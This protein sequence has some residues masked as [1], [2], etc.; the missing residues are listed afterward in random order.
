MRLCLTTFLTVTFTALLFGQ[1]VPNFWQEVTHEQVWLPETAETVT[2]PDSYRLLSL[3]MPAMREY[4]QAAPQEGSAQAKAGKFRLALP[5]PDGSMETFSAWESPIMHPELAAKFPMIKTYAGKS[6]ENPHVIIRFGYGDGGFH[7]FIPDQNGGTV[8]SR[9]AFKQSQYHLCYFNNDVPWSEID[10]PPV[11]CGHQ[12][13]EA[14]S[15]DNVP[16]V[17]DAPLTFRGGGEGKLTER[18]NYAFALACTGEYGISHGGTVPL[19]M[20]TLVQATGILNALLERDNN[21]RLVL[22]S[23]ND[24]LVFINP[25]NDPF[26]N[27]NN[28]HALLDENE[29]ALENLI[30]N[31]NYDVGH[32]FTNG[33]VDVGGVVNGQVCTGGKGRGVTC[34]GSLDVVGI[35]TR[36]AAH[37]M[38]HQFEADHTFNNCPGAGGQFNSS[39]AWEP[40]SGS[41][42][43]SYK[44]SC[45]SNNIPGAMNVHYH[46]G[47]IEEFW[48]FTHFQAGN[49]CPFKIT[50]TNHSPQVELPYTDGFFIPISTPF[51]LEAIA[52]DEDG[53]PLTYSWEQINL[54]PNSPLGMPI[55]DA[56]SFRVYDPTTTP[57]RVFPRLPTILNNGSDNTEVLPT[58]NRNLKFR[59]MVRDN[60]V[61]E[62]AGGIT[63]RDV[64]FNATTT[65]GPFLVTYPN[66][67]SVVWKGGTEVEVKWDVA[68]TTND[69]V[70]CQAVNIRLSVDGGNTYPYLLA[71]ATA[72]D[73]AE[74]VTV[75]DVS[76]SAA[77]VRVEAV[78]NIFFDLSNQNFQVQPA[79][80]PTF[81][82]TPSPLWQQVCVPDNAVLEVKTSAI[83][84]FS[85]PITFEVVDGLPAGAN[86]IFS[87]NPVPV[88]ENTTLTFDLSSVTA[89][90]LFNLTIRGVAG[91]DTI[92]KSLV[93]NVV[94]S[95]FSALKLESP[96]D[97]ATGQG[98]LPVFT[99]T[100]LPQADLYEF[101]LATSPLFEP[102]SIVKELTGLTETT[103]TPNVALLNSKIYYWRI[104]PMNE[105][106]KSNYT[107]TATFQTYTL[108]CAPFQSNDVPIAISSIGLPVIQSSLPVLQSAVITD[109][110][111]KNISG[112]HDALA[113][114]RVTLI[115]PSGTEVVLFEK[116]CGNT[117]LFNLGLDDESPFQ[118]ACP[119]LNGLAYKPQNPLS[120]FIGENALGNWTLKVAVINSLGAGGVLNNWSL[121][122][123]GAISPNNPYLVKND[124][125]GVPPGE[126]NVV[127]A[128]HLLVQDVDNPAHQLTFTML[129]APESGYLSREGVPLSVGGKFTMSDVY[130]SRVRY[131]NTD[132]SAKNDFFTFIVEDGTGG[133]LGTPKFNFKIDP[134]AVTGTDEILFDNDLTVFPNPTSGRLNVAFEHD[135][136]G[137]VALL[138]S[139]VTGR[140]VQRQPMAQGQRTAQ[141]DLEGYAEGIYFLTVLTGKE[142]LAKKFVVRR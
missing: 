142:T 33:C 10:L 2:L 119:P 36:I 132:G 21:V 135:L 45:G 98:L 136:S 75:P 85:A 14:I 9:Y 43:L 91:A 115:S 87:K 60:N 86:A 49:A 129:V 88:G 32:L 112:N 82:V 3:D 134:N 121:E 123:C 125:L 53:D 64:S 6:V 105:C 22:I 126:S 16:V 137:E 113:D 99:W 39:S 133:W 110:N 106:G 46:S 78:N 35:T 4:L 69:K 118:I 79:V 62:G 52:T 117:S 30:G 131:H 92:Y 124:T 31:A 122:F 59:C 77:R 71:S 95:D 101:Q 27:S 120:T 140:L 114:L 19:V 8:I 127:Y 54:G 96:A 74:K 44:G 50:T 103:Y 90:G 47:N 55:G 116:V 48:N 100:D 83:Q 7:A 24:K 102:G 25:N 109:L 104:R 29:A 76:S 108:S 81:V 94:Y 15:Q 72:N 40:G 1:S 128:S 93:F 67:N 23:N 57:K 63:W 139:D 111:V 89:D 26:I 84:G 56:P 51:E 18:R 11:M 66:T 17:Q 65:A 141:L 80:K 12:P 37:E 107:L 20:E 138:V 42:L 13:K 5:L 58:Y 68:N 73:G 61:L 28:G 41:T 97:G 70:N 130:A 38:G 34:H